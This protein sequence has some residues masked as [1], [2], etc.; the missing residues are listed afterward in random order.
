MSFAIRIVRDTATADLRAALRAVKDPRRMW[1]AVG[2]GV[3]SMTKRAFN[4]ASLRPEAWLEKKSGSDATL[5]DTSTLWR[6]VRV[7]K[8][9]GSG[10]IVGSD[11]AYA[12]I[13][14]QGGETRPM[15]RRPFFPFQ[16]SGQPTQAGD[17]VI[18]ET[19]KQY[20]KARGRI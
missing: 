6:S 13:H 18:S 8:A 15:P 12:A 2:V 3:V 7:V 14:Q 4:E 11:R 1:K 10:V 19:I 20:I 17:K 5:K 9:T 16:K